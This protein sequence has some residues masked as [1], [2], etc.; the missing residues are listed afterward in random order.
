MDSLAVEP[1]EC[2]HLVEEGFLRDV[3]A[4]RVAA[5]KA[6]HLV[7]CRRAQEHLV[8]MVLLAK[9]RSHHCTKLL[10]LGYALN[11]LF[12][13][14]SSQVHIKKYTTQLAFSILFISMCETENSKILLRILGYLTEILCYPI[15]L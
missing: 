4:G 11:C 8:L 14:F 3:V 15:E 6:R 7:S 1:Q 9:V 10:V 13:H 12:F 2:D 5:R